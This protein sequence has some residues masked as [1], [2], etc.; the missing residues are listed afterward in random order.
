MA[1]EPNREVET[2]ASDT[3]ATTDAIDF[4]GMDHTE[5]TKHLAESISAEDGDGGGIP[6]PDFSDPDDDTAERFGD[7]DVDPED[8]FA[9]KLE[10]AKAEQDPD[11]AEEEQPESDDDADD[12]E[13][14]RPDTDDD[15]DDDA[16]QPES[17]KSVR[18][19][20]Q[21]K[22]DHEAKAL[23]LKKRNPDMSLAECLERTKP[24][25]AASE[26]GEEGD[27]QPKDELTEQYDAVQSEIEELEKK[28]LDL[29]EEME[30][31]EAAKVAK[32]IRALDKK[33]S[34]LHVQ[35]EQKRLST[36]KEEQSLAEKEYDA[37]EEASKAKAMEFY[38]DV[39]NAKSKLV[40]RMVEI[41]EQLKEAD[42]D[43]YYS[44]D[45][46]L[47]VAQMAAR[48]LS[49]APKTK[50]EPAKAQKRPKPAPVSPAGG[51]MRTTTTNQSTQLEKGLATIDTVEDM[52]DFLAS[53]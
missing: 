41:N 16:D 49:I 2:P 46:H 20:L 31:T 52:E 28:Q 5:I 51:S 3:E 11:Q 22:D 6:A 24:P 27:Q 13:R 45:K 10:K 18:V 50:T 40:A 8:S 14:E 44:P 9:E 47:K 21:P 34:T 1:E 23:E 4:D 25:E 42:D 32:E 29:T 36:E 35:R 53:L 12:D 7:D 19:R 43:L 37:A 15:K 48:D 38:P 30:F 39:T 17:L 26:E 33:L